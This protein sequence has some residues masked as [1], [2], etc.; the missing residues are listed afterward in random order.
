MN[1]VSFP[2]NGN[3]ESF[4]RTTLEPRLRGD[5]GTSKQ[6]AADTGCQSTLS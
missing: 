4:E 1:D 2:R 5:D 3:P 6:D